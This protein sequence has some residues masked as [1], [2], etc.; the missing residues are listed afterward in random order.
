MTDER[1]LGHIIKYDP[2]TQVLIIKCDF[3]DV[4]KQKSLEQLQQNKDLFSFHFKKP[5]RES[6]TAKQLRTYFMLLNQILI[7]LDII[8]DRDTVSALD[9]Y[10]MES[11][12]PCKI[13][14]L[15]DKQ[16]PC[17]ASKSDLTKE[18]FIYLIEI[19]L[20]TYTD[21]NLKIESIE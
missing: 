11:L 19:I 8:P 18:E 15:Y 2:I 21:L 5:Y 20:E 7:K 16:V 12:W 3:I 14:H 9:K 6:K 4:E 1:F 10:I 17:P 13:L